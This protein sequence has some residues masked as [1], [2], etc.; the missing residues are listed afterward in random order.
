MYGGSPFMYLLEPIVSGMVFLCL[1]HF[2]LFPVGA[3]KRK[4]EQMF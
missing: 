1:W 4:A 2:L 3:A